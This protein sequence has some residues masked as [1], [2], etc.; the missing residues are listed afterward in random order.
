MPTKQA[1]ITT[2]KRQLRSSV[3]SST[4]QELP[5]ASETTSSSTPSTASASS[6][7]DE[8]PSTP[9]TMTANTSSATITIAEDAFPNLV[10]VNDKS[11]LSIRKSKAKDKPPSTTT[12]SERWCHN[13][14]TMETPR[15]RYGPLGPYT[16]CNACHLRWKS[17]GEKPKHD[18]E[19]V[20]QPASSYLLTAAT[21]AKTTT[22]VLQRSRKTILKKRI[23][24]ENEQPALKK[25]KA[26]NSAI[27][28]VETSTNENATTL[29]TTDPIKAKSRMTRSSRQP[30]INTT[31]VSESDTIPNDENREE[32]DKARMFDKEIS[33]L[34][35]AFFNEKMP[36]LLKN[37]V[38]P[39]ISCSRCQSNTTPTWR[40][41]PLGPG[42]LCNACGL[43]WA[44]VAGS[45]KATEAKKLSTSKNK[46]TNLSPSA[47]KGNMIP[48]AKSSRP[49]IP[50]QFL[51]HYKKEFLKHGLYHDETR[52]I[53]NSIPTILQQLATT[54]TTK[55]AC[56][57]TTPMTMHTC[58]FPPLP[59][60][61]GEFSIS[62]QRDF[63]LPADILQERELGLIRSDRQPRFIRIRSNI[64]VERK[65]AY[66]QRAL[67]EASVA[68]CQCERPQPSNGRTGCGE[69]C[70][71]RML[72][73]ECDPKYC[74]CGDQCS[75]QR[76]QRKETKKGLQIFQTDNRGW[77]LRTLKPI[78]KGELIIEYRG[79]IISQELCEERMLTLYANEKNFYF[80]DY[81][82]GEVIDAC[83]KGT[84]ARF[85][86]HSCHPNCHIEKWLFRGESH[87]GVFASMDIEPYSEL[88]YDYNFS[89]FNG[90]V[91]SQ[92]PCY[93]GSKDC[94]GT[95]GRKSVK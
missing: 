25:L 41:G 27:V 44:K 68:V 53:T 43:Q 80:L 14:G 87:F 86:N 31:N 1:Y 47:T 12:P 2:R 81:A 69:D 49:K 16:F 48:T 78:K 29:I 23:S 39:R 6:E 60:H 74:P 61:Q 57:D 72:F 56:A 45:T 4:A 64:F 50:H 42:T 20:N 17:R 30:L 90:S 85:I 89:T 13:C 83:T 79:E 33:S 11:T 84:E 82:K 15:W 73:Y 7:I 71:N 92:Q 34:M 3:S 28:R 40:T 22:A 37:C 21:T 46:V 93:C 54:V 9:T 8:E 52:F 26:S 51:L 95:I 32:M 19:F 58:L 70:L 76:F 35:E 66:Q 38:Q 94:R 24:L 91:E 10:P 67:S 65:P 59:I 18:L 62:R 75:N 77:G 55:T 36:H 88:F 63:E 5:S